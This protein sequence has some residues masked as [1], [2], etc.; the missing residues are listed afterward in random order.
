MS[1]PLPFWSPRCH[2]NTHIHTTFKGTISCVFG[3]PEHAVLGSK[4]HG[5]LLTMRAEHEGRI[6]GGSERCVGAASQPC[7]PFGHVLS[8]QTS[9]RP[10]IATSVFIFQELLRMGGPVDT[11]ED[12]GTFSNL[13]QLPACTYFTRNLPEGGL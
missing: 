3:E 13:A 6:A 8:W 7:G 12:H 9:S 1:F 10:A 11:Q 4:N 2:K 5:A